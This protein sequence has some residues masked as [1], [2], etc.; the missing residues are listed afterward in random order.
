MNGS[1]CK[2][3]E[4][5][6]RDSSLKSR[7]YLLSSIGC[8]RVHAGDGVFYRRGCRFTLF[9]RGRSDLKQ[10]ISTQIVRKAES[11]LV[12]HHNFENVCQ[13]FRFISVIEVD[14]GV[15]RL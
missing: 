4:K 2:L 15:M 11:I 10:S 9:L 8:E 13:I 12:L 3:D 1:E 14:A 6:K 5:R 7:A